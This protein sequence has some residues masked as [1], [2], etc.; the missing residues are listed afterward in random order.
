VIPAGRA[1]GWRDRRLLLLAA[2]ALLTVWSFVIPIF[3][4]PDEYLHWQYVRY[5]HEEKR[6][7]IYGPFFAEANSPPLYY[8]LVAPVASPTPGPPPIIWTDATDEPHVLF[9]PR[10]H[11]NAGDDL[12]R[13]WPIR[14]ARLLTVLISLLTIAACMRM[15]AEA[16]RIGIPPS[17]WTMDAAAA[18]AALLTGGLV[19]FLP[20]FAFRGSNI[21]N[22]AL[23]TTLS[24]CTLWGMVTIV[25]RGFTWR[26]GILT[27]VAFAGAYL[28]KINAICLGPALV[29]AI[30]TDTSATWR[31]RLIRLT[32]VLAIT[33]AVVAP[34]SIR[35]VMLYGDPFASHAMNH[36]VA[37]LIIERPLWHISN[38]NSLPRELFKSF[39]AKFG[40]MSVKLHKSVYACYLLFL[41]TAAAGLIIRLRRERAE[42][43]DRGWT[44]A[45]IALI[46]VVI[47]IGNF[48]I[49][50]NINLRF[51]QPQGRYMFPALPA[52]MLAAAL[53][54]QAWRWPARATLAV[55]A[56][57]NVAILLFVVKPAYYPPVVA[58][59][60][61]DIALIRPEPVAGAA[62]PEW[63][64][65][66]R[67]P[68]AKV[69]FMTFE[70]QQPRLAETLPETCAG[71]IV[72]TLTGEDGQTKEIS[73]LFPWR[74]DGT[75]RRAVVMLMKDPRWTGMVTRVTVRP[76][77]ATSAS[78]AAAAEGAA[79]LTLRDF[80]LIGSLPSHDF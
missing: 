38:I 73:R 12:E 46:I 30:V 33:L 64:A 6:L 40:Y 79:A 70:V 55:W 35:N 65:D 57:A 24:A 34:W 72:F 48:L 11:L 68:A 8:A 2:G 29:L 5:L 50:L 53:G 27:A 76:F 51:D 66:V 75:L 56:A 10:L 44:L 49:V 21:S 32:G 17:G 77:A 60:S 80:R 42:G 54:L 25:R 62:T 43:D 9:A 37:G 41:L 4:A 13:Y 26:A 67:V 14:N 78:A 61:R 59:L 63:A 45:R 15:G 47:V 31:Q 36:A 19:A 74:A 52:V 28:S 20:Q 69:N 58:S 39:I 71:S 7:P 1:A 23:V 22:D 3:E 16:G 18:G